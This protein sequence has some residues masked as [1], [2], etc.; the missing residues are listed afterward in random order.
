MK[1]TVNTNISYGFVD[2]VK[3]FFK[4]NDIEVSIKD[5]S[6]YPY[7]K[8]IIEYDDDTESAMSV[9]FM[10]Y[11]HSGIENM[12][13]DYLIKCGVEPTLISVGKVPIAR[14]MKQLD[15]DWDVYRR[16]HLGFR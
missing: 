12:L 4:A 11:R 13:C 8:V 2:L 14:D 16:E 10:S 9:T 6:A 3:T 7:G 1:V 15:K 5:M